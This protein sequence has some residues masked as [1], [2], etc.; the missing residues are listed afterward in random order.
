M[1]AENVSVLRQI[2]QLKITLSGTKPPIWRR[3]LVPAEL[4]LAQLHTVL[5]ISMGWENCHLHEFCVGRQR[6]GVP[7]PDAGMM[8]DDT[9][10][11]KKVRLSDVLPRV[12]AKA[13]YT[14]DFGDGWEHS[15]IL[16]KVLPL[17]SASS[18][19]VCTGGKR[20]APPEDCGGTGGYHN[21]LEAIHDPQNEEHDSLLEW[22]GGSFDPEAFSA[23]DVN[24]QLAPLQRRMAKRLKST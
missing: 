7:D 13:D 3:V 22:I 21:F 8:G 6:F 5:Q 23:E 2:F 10:S 12:G 16:E 20:H 11:E 9:I 15:I 4:T 1:S 19:P 24:R 18:Y 17:E 14:Y